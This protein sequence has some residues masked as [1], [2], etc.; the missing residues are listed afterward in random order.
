MG[1][2][3]KWIDY[4]GQKIFY[5]NYMGLKGEK[6]LE[7]AHET[8]DELLDCGKVNINIL[9]ETTGSRLSP[10]TIIEL[11][12]IMKKFSNKGI[13]YRLA[14]FGITGLQ[15]VIVK[16]FENYKDMYCAKTL[17]DAKEWLVSGEKAK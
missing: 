10:S 12:N 8:A 2:Y 15:K 9:A 17:E 4:K 13:K 11:K 16:G 6:F 5:G 3:V 14:I 1:K 7:A